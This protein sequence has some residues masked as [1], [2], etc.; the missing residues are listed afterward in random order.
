MKATR[1]AGASS[2]RDAGKTVPVTIVCVVR[3]LSDIGGHASGLKTKV[4]WGFFPKC[5]QL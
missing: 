3:D 2:T 1:Q 4:L 5:P